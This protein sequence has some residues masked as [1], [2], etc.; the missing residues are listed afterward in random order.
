MDG[1]LI[2][3]KPADFTSFDV[4]AKM[5]GILRTKKIGHAGTLD[6]MAT[7]VLPLLIGC[8]TKAMDILPDQSKRYTAR[9]RL[10]ISTDTQ[11]ITGKILRE[12]PVEAT[13]KDVQEASRLFVGD[14]MQ[15]PP[16]YSAVQVNGRR[17]YDLA[18]AGIEIERKARPATIRNI[19]LKQVDLHEYELDV[20]CEK[21]TYIRTICHD[22]GEKLGCGAAMTYLRR[23]AASGFTLKNAI[24]IAEAQILKDS[25]E[26]T[27]KLLPVANLFSSLP[28]IS[29][30][31][32]RKTL[33][34]NGVKITLESTAGMFSVYGEEEF[35]GIANTDDSGVILKRKLFVQ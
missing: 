5:R 6:P 15:L 7:G 28:K 31:P 20:L 3:D 14:I 29:L 8:A 9:M 32:Y 22:I 13:F 21:G 2:I 4:V 10:G 30:E 34:L 18:R 25:G 19:E 1:I 35:L 33:F 24:T 16:M 23:T 11:D 12:R 17:L 27:Q 26:I